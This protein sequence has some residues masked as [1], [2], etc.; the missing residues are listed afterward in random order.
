[1]TTTQSVEINKRMYMLEMLSKERVL[2]HL[3]PRHADVIVPAEWKKK[4]GMML[5]VGYDLPVPIQHLSVSDEGVI[6]VFS[7]NRQPFSC[8]IPWAAV[9]GIV[10]DSSQRF[11]MWSDAVSADL[12][13]ELQTQKQQAALAKQV[14]PQSQTDVKRP[15]WFRGVIDG[16]KK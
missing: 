2:L 1:M 4:A 9:Y 8:R 15:S 7:F 12:V 10:G 5:H 11:Q 3:N 14:R 13:Q 16:D 6:G